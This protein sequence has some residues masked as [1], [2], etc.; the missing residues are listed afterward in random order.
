[1]MAMTR[2]QALFFVL[3]PILAGIVTIV[4]WIR[5]GFGGEISLWWGVP[6]VVCTAISV[7][8]T[9]IWGS[10]AVVW[11]CYYLYQLR[12]VKKI[13]NWLGEDAW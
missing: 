3:L 8:A 4:S 5:V 2:G 11:G 12:A 1:M 6:I 7:L 10:V 9:F 13:W